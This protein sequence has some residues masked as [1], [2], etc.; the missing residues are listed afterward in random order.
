MVIQ[1][2]QPKKGLFKR[3]SKSMLKKA[4]V[5]EITG[6]FG[7]FFAIL[8]ICALG[9]GFFSGVRITTP[10]M[11][12]TI[13][14]FYEQHAFY[15]LRLLST[16]GWEKEDVTA[17]EEQEHISDAEGSYQFDL[18]CID[19]EGNDI[20]LKTHSITNKINTLWVTEGRLPQK[21]DE[22]L[23]DYRSNCGYAI[24]D[25]IRFSSENDEDTLEHFTH[26]AYQ[27]VGFAESPLYI[28]FE[29]GSTALGN[30]TVGGFAYL[31]PGGY[32]D[33]VY[34]EIYVKADRNFELYSDAYK[35]FIDDLKEELEP[36]TGQ[37]ADERYQ[38]ILSDANE[39]LGDAKQ[40]LA[41]KEKEGREELD[42]AR[43]ELDDAKIELSDAKKEIDDGKSEIAKN[44][45]KLADA[46]KE[47]ADAAKELADGKEKLDDGKKQLQMAASEIEKGEKELEDNRGK[48]SQAKMQLDQAK[49]QLDETDETLKNAQAQLDQA[50]G[51][52][53]NALAQIEEGE[54][55]L[56]GEEQKLMAAEAYGMMDPE[57]LAGAKA[58]LA[59][60]RQ[61]LEQS[62][63]QYNAGMAKYQKNLAAYQD[64]VAQYQKGLADYNKGMQEYR[65]GEAQLKDGESKIAQA[66]K[67]YGEGVAKWNASVK[68]YEDGLAEYEDGK[69]EFEKGKK[70]LQK[71]KKDLKE[72]EKEYEDGLA[73]YEDGLAEYEDGKAEFDEK[74]A[75]AKE[76][77]R[78]AE[79]ELDDLK[80][81]DTYLLGRDTNIGYV[82]FESDSQIVSQVAR[83]FPIFFILVAALVCMTTMT[84]MV[85]EQRGYIGTL[86][87]LGYTPRDIM[88]KFT[89]YSGFAAFLGSVIGYG[90][91]IILFPSV[92]WYAY[93]MM[94]LK[95]PLQFYVDEKLA[96]ASLVTALLCS[97]G[98]TYLSCRYELAETAASLMRP[99][100]PAPGKRVFLEYLPFIWNRM[101][102]L[103]K[104]SVR[105]I[106]RYKRRFF[107]MIVGISGCSALLLTGFGMKDSVAGF[108]A[109]QYDEILTADAQV[110]FKNGNQKEIPPSLLKLLEEETESYTLL[111]T[112]AWDLVTKD[113]AKGISLLVPQD[114]KEFTKYFRLHEEGTGIEIRLPKQGEILL[115]VA[116]A[117]RYHIEKGDQITL[118]SE[119]ME[120]VQLK[121]AGIFENHVY[122]YVIVNPADFDL[123]LNAAY[124]MFPE[125]ADVYRSQ[126]KIA[127]N[128]NVTGVTVFEDFKVRMTNM[129]ESLNLV[130][131]VVILSA[132][133]LAFVVLY[134]LTNINITERLRE[135]ATIKVLGFYPG[136][137]A[138]YVFRENYLL[139]LF[140]VLAGLGLGVLL[141]RFVMAQIIVDM[142]HFKV[143]IHRE[144]YLYSIVLTFLFTF[145]VSLLMR[146]KLENID[147]AQSLKSVE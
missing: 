112:G 110:D 27:V 46:D 13:Q 21:D 24:G 97:I 34:S 143:V 145:L 52:L 8:A 124:V 68:E 60:A 115:C 70:E 126:T 72:G 92:I 85:E 101:K 117:D 116:L 111:S 1:Y 74:I 141:H 3:P 125:G 42:D 48:L 129:M 65:E 9:V 144:S 66:K 87:A 128:K 26:D 32:A 91:G 96:A 19:P 28:N 38:R 57:T 133:G 51:Q 90:I 55:S 11:K 113:A 121:V 31:T 106:F 10:A 12:K 6:S 62:K 15:D 140:G 20:V 25:T 89:F 99:K 39:E 94:Y 73:E 61:T 123:D 40:E 142:V 100:A 136:E 17:F 2:K 29:R 58:Q 127:K 69:A 78:D 103:H 45:G 131:L 139:T 130:V 147:M 86:K 49:K 7:R 36:F 41:D 30:G 23:M 44:E 88:G 135:I 14:S 35:D 63:A 77:I 82:C 47:L 120:T 84:R 81:P 132:A 18:I 33:E 37:R 80:E 59:Q 83:V 67:A 122:N 114:E 93:L 98:T 5:R 16:L 102:F 22:I 75:D 134:N 64:G 43:K 119:D 4:T 146:R 105:N 95:L 53:M 109:A 56:A 108:A 76:K 118:R 137:T 138:S 104:V 107:M 71:G 50:S 79:D 54:N